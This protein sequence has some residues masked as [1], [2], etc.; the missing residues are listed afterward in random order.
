LEHNPPLKTNAVIVNMKTNTAPVYVGIDVAKATLQVHLRGAQIELHNTPADLAK[1]CKKLQALPGAHVICEATGGYEQP[2]V[3]RVQKAQLPVS[4][5]NPAQ[6]RAAAQ[7]KGQRAKSDPIDA[8][9]LT[10]YG[11]R[12]QPAPTPPA[13][14][15]QRELAAL[16]QWLQQLIDAQAI[17]KTQAEHHEEAFVRKQH[18]TLIKHYQSQI[19][20]AEAKLKGLMEQDQELKQRVECLDAIAGVGLRTALVVLSHLPELGQLNRREVAALA[21][22][23]PW[24]RDSGTMK[25]KRC[26]GGGRPKVRVALH[27]SSVSAIRCNPILR[28]FYQRLIAKGKPAK[29][30][31]TAVMRKLLVYMNHHCHPAAAT[32]AG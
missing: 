13:S 8:L 26:I 32:G 14:K 3:Q 31:L 23:A 19:E 22:L 1:L 28:A 20:K 29:I 27:M 15:V 17:A 7:A 4:V 25:G 2:L 10:D 16:T 12:Y 21:G 24:T 11:Q 9:G 18:Q 30:A 6:V 5:I